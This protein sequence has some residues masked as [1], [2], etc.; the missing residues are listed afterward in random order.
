MSGKKGCN[1]T[2]EIPAECNISYS[3]KFV[4][5]DLNPNFIAVN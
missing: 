1:Q 5:T 3:L 4:N 2:I